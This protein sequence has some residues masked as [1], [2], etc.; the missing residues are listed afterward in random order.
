LYLLS[1]VICF[2]HER[3]Y[4]PR[5]MAGAL[6]LIMLAAAVYSHVLAS[7]PAS[8]RIELDVGLSFAG[9]FA[10]CMLCHG[11]LVRLKPDPRYLT[12]FYLMIAAG[13]ALG[14]LFV[15]VIAPLIFN[16]Y[17][18]RYLAL[19]GGLVLAIAILMGTGERGLFKQYAVGFLP[20]TALLAMTVIAAARLGAVTI[21]E[22]VRPIDVRRNFYGVLTVK[23]YTKG[24]DDVARL[25]YN[26][27]ILHG[28]QFTHSLERRLPTAYFGWNSGVGRVMR[29]Y[30]AKNSAEL[31]VGVIGLGTGTIAAY[32]RPQDRFVFYEINP[33]VLNASQ[34]YFTFLAD[35]ENR[36]AK[37]GRRP[38]VVMGDARLS[39]V[40]DLAA[41]GG[42]TQFDVIVLDAFTGDAIPTHFLTREAADIYRRHVAP[43]GTLAIHITNRYLNLTPVA[44]GLADYLKLSFA[45]IETPR[46]KERGEEAADWAI[47]TSN[48]EL[49]S[50][51]ESPMA[52]NASDHDPAATSS[53]DP[54]SSASLD[55][56][57]PQVSFKEKSTRPPLLWTDDFSDLF[58]VLR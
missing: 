22:G 52:T 45:E 55:F 15:G 6:L 20:A 2:D 47:I 18:E 14:G 48:S 42:P 37:N 3:W 39:L 28:L 12:S 56:L 23:E 8:D 44:H 21:T 1:F 33:E 4:W 34:Q 25:L 36:M 7:R 29:F 24:A 11:E 35:A 26:G 27:H 17:H 38:E 13:G 41:P 30:Q 58:S 50:A 40:R 53:D 9:L 57:G 31:R 5:T 46:V 32:A 19:W 49:R 54:K 16:G 10:L 43:G 51:L